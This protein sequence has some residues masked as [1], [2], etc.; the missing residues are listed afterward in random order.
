MM[1]Y[2]EDLDLR[3]L[4][5]FSAEDGSI[6]LSE[7]RMLLLHAAS[8]GSLREEMMNSV[9]QAATRRMFTRM[10]FASGMR[11]AELARKIRG[12]QNV[13]DAFATGPQM[14]MLEGGV[15]V[16]PVSVEMDVGKGEFQGEFIWRN[17][18]EAEAHVKAFGPQ[19]DPVCWCLSG[20]A[21][22]YTSAF[23]GRFILFKETRCAACS[24]DECR[25]V[26]KPAEEWP[27]AEEY[28]AYFEPE[29]IVSQMLELSSQVE[30][31]RSSLAKCRRLEDMVGESPAF[32]R[33]F[34]L[35]EKAAETSVTVLLSG[36]T[37]VGKERFARAIHQ[38]SK[39]ADQPFVAI[40]CAALPHDLIEAELFG[41]EKGAFTGATSSRPGKF[42]RAD[43]GT[44]FLDELGELPLASQAKLLRALQEGE[45]ERLG[46]DRPRKIDVRIVAATNV[47]LPEA[48]KAGRFRADLYYRLNVYPI[49]IPPLRERRGDIPSMIAMMV[50]KFCALH[51]K[52]VS[53]V[54]D[55]A[56]QALLAHA[57]PGNVRE[58][59]NMIERGVILAGQGDSI[60][61]D[62]LFP[63]FVPP[64]DS[65]VGI[66]S[67]GALEDSDREQEGALCDRILASG[68]SLEQMENMVLR[69]AV[70]RCK[71]NLSGA[72]RLLGMTRPQ[73]SY[74]LKR[75]LIEPCDAGGHH[76][77]V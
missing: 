37:G 13:E 69:E 18:W 64:A 52:R 70:T 67:T 66:D 44:L 4:I 40:N 62:D 34:R 5:R 6:W 14:H 71:G 19:H 61:C 46:D 55:R 77:Q 51:Q 24:H 22:G 3:R 15:Q 25:I 56:M 16:V 74:R 49:L 35:V 28:M 29:S 10:G 1:K 47:D 26:G 36:E 32:R 58:L 39:R 75:C 8:L 68:L 20:Y 45:I 60:E 31:L 72:A 11:D 27:D 63:N 7:S 65:P 43:G 41:V 53:G 38:R 2:P 42:E 73:L 76:A 9:G 48:V 30:A 57:W 59:E 12:G 21:S 50:E 17:S 54:T 33:A 23:M